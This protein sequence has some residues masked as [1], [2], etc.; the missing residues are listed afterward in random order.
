MMTLEQ[1]ILL[2]TQAHE[3]QVDKGGNPYIDHPIAVMNRVSTLHEKM[4]AVLHDVVEDTR[5][6][7]DD[8]RK[9]GVPEEVVDAVDALTRREDETYMEFVARAKKHPIARNVKIADI[10]ENL[11]LSRIPN[12]T[13]RD[14]DRLKRYKKALVFLQEK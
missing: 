11:D 14:H 1:V 5:W 3:G 12:P 6:S 10:F 2:A 9:V 4:A 13:Q 8:L 7:F